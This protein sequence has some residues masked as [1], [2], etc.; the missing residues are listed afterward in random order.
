MDELEQI[1][2]IDDVVIAEPAI[3]NV[4]KTVE[5]KKKPVKKSKKADLV[6]RYLTNFDSSSEVPPTEAEVKAFTVAK[7]EMLCTLQ[8][9]QQTHKMKPS[10]LADT[11]IGFVSGIMDSLAQTDNEITRMNSE[12]QELKRCVSEELGSLA[13]LLNNKVKIA[14]HVVLNGGRAIVNK[15]KSTASAEKQNVQ[16]KKQATERP[17]ESD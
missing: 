16:R 1:P 10:G 11:L 3:L 12:D 9:K 4:A 5:K 6:K 14:S 15:R 7:L 2:E 13:T 17:P 8:Q